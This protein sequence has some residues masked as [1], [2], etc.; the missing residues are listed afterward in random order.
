MNYLI[1]LIS[2]LFFSLNTQAQTQDSL[3]LN[4]QRITD[5]LLEKAVLYLDLQTEQYPGFQEALYTH[6][7][8]ARLYI[9]QH[10]TDTSLVTNYL[11]Q[12]WPALLSEALRPVLS[13][14]QI[15]RLSERIHIQRERRDIDQR[16][17]YLHKPQEYLFF[18]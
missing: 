15:H 5:A 7:E 1:I 16:R 10:G 2:I 3:Q 4:N 14:E 11:E 12:Q 9:V 6:L 18:F 17:G 8:Q 13:A